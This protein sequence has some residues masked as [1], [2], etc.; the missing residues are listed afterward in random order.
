[1]IIWRDKTKTKLVEYF[2]KCAF[3]P[4]L[5]TF[6]RAIRKGH[7]LTWPGINDINLEKNIMNLVPTAKGHLDQERSNLQS[8]KIINNKFLKDFEPT[9]GDI[10]TKQGN[11]H[12]NPLVETNI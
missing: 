9:N 8:S 11:F 2:H 1:M 3:S 7:F 10:Q 4:S 5:S 6:Q 12:I